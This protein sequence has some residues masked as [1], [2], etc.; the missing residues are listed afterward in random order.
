M[1]ILGLKYFANYWFLAH[2]IF[3]E[4]NSVYKEINYIVATL[5]L[6]YLIFF[7]ILFII[8]SLSP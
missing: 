2:F 1:V 4:Y 3:H 5:F 8:V 6:Y 7:I